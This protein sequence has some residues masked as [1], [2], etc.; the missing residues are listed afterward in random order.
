MMSGCEFLR[1]DHVAGVVRGT[2][3]PARSA[4]SRQSAA[5]A[6][7]KSLASSTVSCTALSARR[8]VMT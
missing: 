3:D 7:S 4:G 1:Q 6:L 8:I 2:D 5:D